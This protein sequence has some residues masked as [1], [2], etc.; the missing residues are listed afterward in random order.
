MHSKHRSGNT[1]GRVQFKDL[2]EE[3]NNIKNHLKRISWNS[4]D[5]NRLAKDKKQDS[6]PWTQL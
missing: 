5:Y 1:K 3:K 2:G 4:V 6:A